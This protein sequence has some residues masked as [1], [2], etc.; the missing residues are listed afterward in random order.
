MGGGSTDRTRIRAESFLPELANALQER[1]AKAADSDT[2][3]G[4]L[5]P[6]GG[7]FDEPVAFDETQVT[8]PGN[9]S[10]PKP[11][12]ACH[13]LEEGARAPV[14]AFKAGQGSKARSL[15]SAESGSQHAPAVAIRTAQT[16]SNG[17]GVDQSGSSY[18]LDGAQGQ[19]IQQ[20][21]A[22]RRLT[23]REC[24]RLQGFPDD[25]TLVP[26]RGKPAAD[27]PRYKALGNSW[28]VPCARWIG[29]RIVLVQRL[30]DG[31][32]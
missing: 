10:N 27:G 3:P 2:K 18:T 30:I 25:Y 20:Q 26:Y 6:V 8:S 29:E 4:H 12:D 9:R 21:M 23:P 31:T 22:V 28:A 13:P 24:E 5:I 32:L 14:I 1:D 19:A 16:S 17:W 7:F 15:G 11:G